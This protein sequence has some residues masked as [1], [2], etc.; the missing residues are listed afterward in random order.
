MTSAMREALVDVYGTLLKAGWGEPTDRGA[1]SATAAG[2]ELS[3]ETGLVLKKVV[4][5]IRRL[6]RL[7]R[8]QASPTP[9][10]E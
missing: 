1:E 7:R 5:A 9:P 8:L 4:R 6:Q 10:H 2:L 3:R